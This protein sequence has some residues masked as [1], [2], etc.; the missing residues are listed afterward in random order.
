MARRE[1]NE[2]YYR[3]QQEKVNRI[4]QMFTTTT[5]GVTAVA[6]VFVLNPFSERARIE[7]LKG[8]EDSLYYHVWVNESINFT[9][10]SLALVFETEEEVFRVP[11]QKGETYGILEG[12]RPITG[13]P[14]RIE[15]SEGFGV[16]T[17]VS[18][19]VFSKNEPDFEMYKPIIRNSIEDEL[20]IYDFETY[21]QDLNKEINNLRLTYGYTPLLTGE[22]VELSNEEI[23]LDQAIEIKDIPNQNVLIKSKITADVPIKDVEGNISIENVAL[24]EDEFYTPLYHESSFEIIRVIDS[25]IEYEVIPDYRFLKEVSYRIT[26]FENDRE[27]ESRTLNNLN[28]ET[29]HLLRFERLFPETP[30]RLLHE[31]LFLD[32]RTNEY[33]SLVVADEVIITLEKFDFITTIADQENRYL[34]T[35]V[36]EDVNNLFGKAYYEIRDGNNIVTSRE[37]DLRNADI[38]TKFSEFPILKTD[39]VNRTLIFG[40]IMNDAT[41]TRYEIRKLRR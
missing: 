12:V 25:V 35:I 4:R 29:D 37:F 33:D 18:S 9:E 39:L 38:D 28:S 34:I 27:L 26:I 41:N 22:Y 32:H 36:V 14:A 13:Y 24:D 17:I 31:M 40:V 15:G 8:F 6:V 5:V 7:E 30:Y 3:E 20:L 11:L 23:T 1:F 2:D 16:N 19:G 21:Y 10:G